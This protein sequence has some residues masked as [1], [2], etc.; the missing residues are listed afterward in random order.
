MTTDDYIDLF[1]IDNK[2]FS[3]TYDIVDYLVKDFK[4]E[5]K[6]IH[7]FYNSKKCKN[8]ICWDSVEKSKI[9]TISYCRQLNTG[10]NEDFYCKEFEEK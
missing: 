1:N 8:C 4:K 2:C 9:K 5:K 10:T 7:E 3:K 6:L